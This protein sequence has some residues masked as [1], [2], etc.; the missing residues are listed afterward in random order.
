MGEA[1]APVKWTFRV[2]IGEGAFHMG[3]EAPRFNS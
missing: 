2:K 1:D 3:C